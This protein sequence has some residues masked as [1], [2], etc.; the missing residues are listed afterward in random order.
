MCISKIRHVQNDQTKKKI[1]DRQTHEY[2]RTR[3]DQMS[4]RLDVTWY[5]HRIEQ[6]ELSNEEYAQSV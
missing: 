1:I 5:M 6:K 4:D 3:P 2:I